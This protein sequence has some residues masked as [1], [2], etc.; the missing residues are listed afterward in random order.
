MNIESMRIKSYRSFAVFLRGVPPRAPGLKR[1]DALSMPDAD[2]APSR[3]RA[4]AGK[5]A[6]RDRRTRYPVA[7]PG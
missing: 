7:L 1:P 2:G 5:R 3:S 6:G 4:E